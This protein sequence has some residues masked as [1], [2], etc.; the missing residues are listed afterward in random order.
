M[1]AID[2]LA[3]VD[4]GSRL[5]ALRAVGAALGLSNAQMPDVN[6][7]N[8]QRT[9]LHWINVARVAKALPALPSLDYTG[10][11]PALN[12]LIEQANIVNPPTVVNAPHVDASGG[13]AAGD[14][15]SCTMGIWNNEPTGYAYQWLRGG[16]NIAGQTTNAHTIVAADA[17]TILTCRVTAS[18][19]A[20]AG[21]PSISNGVQC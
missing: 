21:A 8:S 17:G 19:A 12:A 11:V 4:F 7:A 13:T 18:N 14:V 1:A 16:T 20:G 15:L 3:D 10:F 6:G 5:V 2:E 9:Y